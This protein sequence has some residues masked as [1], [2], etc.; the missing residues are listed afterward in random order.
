MAMSGELQQTL[1]I[2]SAVAEEATDPWWVIGSA[3]VALLGVEVGGVQ[4]VDLL[5]SVGDAERTLQRLGLRPIN[6]EPSPRFRSAVLGA[7]Q[8]PP[9]PVEI[10]GGFSLSTSEGWRPVVPT[11]RQ[12]VTIQ[13]FALFVPSATELRQ[14]LI[15]F[16]REKDLER[17]RLLGA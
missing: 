3:A 17:A 11:T 9:L 16:G 10:L 15:S 4:D 5:M 7:W 8:A 14:I 13:G 6:K 2:V 12:R 1:A